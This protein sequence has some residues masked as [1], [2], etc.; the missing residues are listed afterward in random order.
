MFL[1]SVRTFLTQRAADV[2]AAVFD[3][4]DALAVEFVASAANL[5]SA[6]YGIPT[7]TLF[8]AK[9]RRPLPQPGSTLSAWADAL[10]PPQDVVT[11][12]GPYKTRLDAWWTGRKTLLGQHT[13]IDQVVG[14]EAAARL[15]RRCGV[16]GHAV[17]ARRGA[18]PA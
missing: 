15:K 16:A 9:A 14:A 6:A 13:G 5:R 8:A 12:C 17:P 11:G 10:A 7:Q 2:G 4:D 1:E 3:K 18:R